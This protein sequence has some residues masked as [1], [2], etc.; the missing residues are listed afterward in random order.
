MQRAEWLMGI[1]QFP[2]LS[3]KQAK[4]LHFIH[5]NYSNSFDVTSFND[6]KW[7]NWQLSNNNRPN[8]FW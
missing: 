5:F 8:V 3:N 7:N 6:I 1:L 2:V 4:L